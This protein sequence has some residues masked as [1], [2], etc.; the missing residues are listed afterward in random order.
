MRLR[1]VGP[2]Y[3]AVGLEGFRDVRSWGMTRPIRTQ[4]F[5]QGC[6]Q[7]HPIDARVKPAHDH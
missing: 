4:R 7:P 3:I 1:D 2:L 6:H 5:G